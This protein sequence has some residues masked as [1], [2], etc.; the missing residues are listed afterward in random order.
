MLS[1]SLGLKK[2]AL[3]LKKCRFAVGLLR[4]APQDGLSGT[5]GHYLGSNMELQ[6]LPARPGWGFKV[7][8][9]TND[10]HNS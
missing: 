10:A 2:A 4:H 3:E 5:K 8:A 9:N 1:R 6:D 7:R